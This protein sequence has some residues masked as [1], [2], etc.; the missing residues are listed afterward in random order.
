M[1]SA[2]FHNGYPRIVGIRALNNRILSKCHEE[3]RDY[4]KT[5]HM[6][7]PAVQELYH[8]TNNN[9]L[10]IIYTHG[11]QPP[12]DMQASES[13]PISGGKGLCTS[14]CNNDCQYCTERHEWNQC[15]M[16]GLGIYLADSP[17]KSHHYV[18][19]P[20]IGTNGR[21]TYRIVVCSVLGKSFQV[22]GHLR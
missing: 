14:L 6:E 5:K 22:E 10:E 19:Q 20:R 15:H 1:S 7:E 17:Q 18:S 11:L 13:C 8:G 12:S 9:I 21:K 2:P 16:F 4:L 3:Y